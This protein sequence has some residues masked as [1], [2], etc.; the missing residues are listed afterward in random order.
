[1][2]R[3][4][5]I[6]HFVPK[7]SHSPQRFQTKLLLSIFRIATPVIGIVCGISLLM[8]S[9]NYRQTVIN[10][11]A[12]A[13]EKVRSDIANLLENT[14]T[15]SQDMIFNSAIQ[16][17][18]SDSTSGEQFP[19]NADVSYH[20]NGFIANRDYINCV[21]LTGH[22]QTLYSTEKAFTSISDYD[23][24]LHSRWLATLQESTEPFLWFVNPD[25]RPV[26]DETADSDNN[27][28]SSLPGASAM[29]AQPAV[30]QGEPQHLMMA[31]PVYSV[32]DYTTRLGYLVMYLDDSYLCDLLNGFQ[33]GKTTNTWLVNSDGTAILRSTVSNDYSFLLDELDPTETGTILSHNGQKFVINIKPVTQN[34]WYIYTATPFSEVNEPLSIFL[35]Q[36]ILLALMMIVIL[37]F[38]AA[39]T[40][41]A[42]SSPIIYLAHN[43]DN[44]R[45]NTTP[46][47]FFMHTPRKPHPAE[48]PLDMKGQPAEIIQIY[49]SYQQMVA[50]INT[51]IRENYVKNLEKK[52]AELALLQSQ[53]NPHFL[54]NTLDSINWMAISNDQDEI[55]EMVTALSDM[56]R[57]SLTKSK[58]SFILLSQE[59]DYVRSYLLL[60]Q[61]RYQD[62]L[63]IAIDCPDAFGSF[64]VPRFTLQPL[65][66]N[67]IKHGI[68]SPDVPFS[69]NLQVLIQKYELHILIG[70]DGSRISLEH[71]KQLLD[72]DASQHEL[73][74]F[75]E[76]SYGVQNIHR[77]IQLICGLQYGL[78]YFIRGGR[79]YCDIRLPI[80]KK[81]NTASPED[82]NHTDDTEK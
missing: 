72:F 3:I 29:D 24:I 14:Q 53:I 8:L 65:V 39:R 4:I 56:F 57:L 45:S 20:I 71:M 54:Y 78:S 80:Q 32:T 74:D 68:I 22:N 49:D 25:Y 37:F 69:I 33:F 66:E 81:E 1:M 23:T 2:N 21:V 79:T 27:T 10:S 61:F 48:E 55:S 77:R 58:S 30:N 16:Q 64:L 7:H 42:L 50:R 18:L 9:Q 51:L 52:D 76:S 63:D 13:T 46:E 44:Y 70:N 43:M 82:G 5:N 60:Q 62:C 28:Y 11:Q 6:K 59:L 40:T 73:L 19:Q 26:T 67:A 36:S 47:P 15:V 34:G 17:I 31:R 75:D 12:A 38:L 35:L 41:T